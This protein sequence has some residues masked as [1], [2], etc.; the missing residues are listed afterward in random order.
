MIHQKKW[1]T[2]IPSLDDQSRLFCFPYAGGGTGIYHSW[3]RYFKDTNVSI[4]PVQLPGR[5]SRLNEKSYKRMTNLVEDL[6]ELIRPYIHQPF[7]FFGH[8][9]GALI[10][11]ELARAI[12]Q[13][14]HV[15]PN[16]LFLSARHAPHLR[17]SS[18]Y[19]YQL[20]DQDLLQELR[21]LGG[22]KEEVLN[23]PELARLI[24]PIIRS[25]FELFETFQYTHGPPLPC[26]V[27]VLGGEQDN[28]VKIEELFGW[29][30]LFTD[31]MFSVRLFQGDHFYH[32]QHTQ[33]ITTII[34]QDMHMSTSETTLTK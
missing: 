26:N 27:T 19:K 21:K 2:P 8:S 28:E 5:E 13:R 9:M 4:Y 33:L 32:E 14:Y 12:H 16:H 20:S 1:L 29:K 11:Y 15:L 25:D 18:T 3:K 17:N 31:G 10:S 34:K 22:T 7:A 6:V 24:L 23:H 30:D